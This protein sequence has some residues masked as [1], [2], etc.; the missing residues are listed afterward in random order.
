MA[1]FRYCPA[2]GASE[3]KKPRFL[4]VSFGDGYQQRAADGINNV[5]RQWQLTF[6]SKQA[7]IDEIRA[8][9][10]ARAG[11]E[12]FD[13][14]PPRGAAGRWIAPEW[15][16]QINNGGDNLTVTFVEVFGEDE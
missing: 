5:I 9:L 4:S 13:W 15:N 2:F 6:S 10:D 11:A 16:S 8:F 12:S 7:R 3:Q 1:E 14:T